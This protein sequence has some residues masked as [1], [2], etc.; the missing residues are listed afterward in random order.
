MIVDTGLCNLDSIARA[1]EQCQ[2]RS[3]VVTSDPN[4]LDDAARIILP[5]VGAFPEAMSRLTS[6]GMAD[7]MREQAIG[8]NVPFLGICLG[9]ELLATLG[10]EVTP[11]PG[12]G[13]ISGEV[14][15]LRPE[16]GE[17]LPH[18]GWNEVHRVGKPALLRD[19]DDGRDFY[20][21][22]SY[23]FVPSD[24][25][26]VAATTPYGGGFVSAVERGNVFGVQFHPE[27]SQLAGFQ[28]LSNFLTA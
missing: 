21:V 2:G 5:G 1:V 18:V 28:V 14:R 26:V 4:D 11:T 19:L 17:R 12:L 22:H 10:H 15:P 3:P 8:R 6:T 25:E 7:A 13:W 20:F 9:M 27:K 24:R 16:P 23:T